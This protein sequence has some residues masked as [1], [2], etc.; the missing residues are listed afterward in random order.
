MK[1]TQENYINLMKS[2]NREREN[3]E[4]GNMLSCFNI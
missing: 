3:G 2:L 1:K 4:L